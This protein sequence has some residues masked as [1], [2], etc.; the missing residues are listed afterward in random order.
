MTAS[1]CR[2]LSL[3]EFEMRVQLSL[4]MWIAGTRETVCAIHRGGVVR[5]FGSLHY[6][7]YK[8]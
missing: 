6:T 2:L 5:H 8:T 3:E 4:K 1:L 7:Q